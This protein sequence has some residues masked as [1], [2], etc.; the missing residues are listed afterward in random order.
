MSMV[1]AGRVVPFSLDGPSS[2]EDEAFPGKVW[3]GDDGRVERVPDR[4]P[5]V[6]RPAP[7]G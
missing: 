4:R 6:V 3:I 2:S 1:I 5:G 7:N